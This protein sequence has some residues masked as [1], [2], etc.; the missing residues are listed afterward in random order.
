MSFGLGKVPFPLLFKLVPDDQYV[1]FH[2][3]LPAEGADLKAFECDGNFTG[4]EHAGQREH[5]AQSRAYPDNR[6]KSSLWS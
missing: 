5:H 2:H 3:V 4:P 1:P 6:G